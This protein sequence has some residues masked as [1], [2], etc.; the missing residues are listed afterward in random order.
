MNHQTLIVTLSLAALSMVANESRAQISSIER[1]RIVVDSRYDAQPDKKATKFLAPY[2]EEVD[3]SRKPVVGQLAQS[4]SAAKPE[5]LLS[6]LLSDIL[7]YSSVK[8]KERPDFAVYNVGGMRAALTKGDVTL[9]NI[10]DVAPFE[11]KICFLTLSGEKTLEL[12]RQIASRMGEGVSRGVRLQ[13][14]PKGELLSAEINGEPISKDRSYRV[15]TLDYLAEGNDQLVA[16]KSKTDVVAP[17][18]SEYNVREII[19]DYFRERTRKGEVVDSK[20]EG[21]ITINDNAQ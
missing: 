18:G 11:N 8:F 13:I 2:K 16:F 1:S 7:I 5:S 17:Q 6:N 10:L 20:I 14:S 3:K 19:A 21:R 9:G 15:V 12:M 4:M